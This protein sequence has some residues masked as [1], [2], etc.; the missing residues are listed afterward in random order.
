MRVAQLIVA[1]ASR[2]VEAMAR[3]APLPTPIRVTIMP[4]T[5][6]NRRDAGCGRAKYGQTAKKSPGATEEAHDH[7]PSYFRSDRNRDCRC[8]RW[9]TG[10]A[11]AAIAP[12]ASDHRGG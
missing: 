3:E 6:S 10:R 2:A 8:R 5:C 7:R 9:H 11:S 4:A 1:T 12:L